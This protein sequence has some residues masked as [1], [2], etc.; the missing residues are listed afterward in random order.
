[1]QIISKPNLAEYSS[2]H[3][4][5]L[6][7]FLYLP[8]TEE[9]VL[10]ALSE[11]ENSFILGGGTNVIFGD[12][13]DRNIISLSKFQNTSVDISANKISVSSGVKLSRLVYE[14]V[15]GGCGGCEVLAGIPGTVGG[16]V[17]MNA[18]GKYGDIGEYI[19]SV[20]VYSKKMCRVLM[21][22]R[23]DMLFGYRSSI[24]QGSD[25]LVVLG[26]E[27]CFEEKGSPEELVGIVHRIIGERMT[28]RIKLPNCGSVFKN[29]PHELSVGA[30]VDRLNLK[31]FTIGAIA[32]SEV[33]G[34]IF[35]NKSGATYSDFIV[36]KNYVASKIYQEYGVDLELEIRVLT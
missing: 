27:L 17:V 1:M 13:F 22:S 6:G 2:I 28:S 11:Q 30:M 3:I 19:S 8:Q 4:G 12:S 9:E 20:K 35:V 5:G 10:S 16:A 36:L 33:H 31:G 26:A 21:L 32:V 15:R 24:L 7:N 23:S 29:P 25:D 18:G 34:N 14:G